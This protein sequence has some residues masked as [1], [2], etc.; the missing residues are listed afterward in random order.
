MKRIIQIDVEDKA[1]Y[2]GK[3]LSIKLL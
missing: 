1:R 3:L 2:D